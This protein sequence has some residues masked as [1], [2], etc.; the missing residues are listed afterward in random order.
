MRLFCFC[1]PLINALTHRA[2]HRGP[3]ITLRL[4][5]P[6]NIAPGALTAIVNEKALN[7]QDESHRRE[8]LS[9]DEP[10]VWRYYRWRAGGHSIFVRLNGRNSQL[11]KYFRLIE[12]C[13]NDW[14]F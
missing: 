7:N 14:V 8:G 13:C 5:D 3:L 1:L 6:T 11:G 10:I 9:A 2:F 12:Q 4:I